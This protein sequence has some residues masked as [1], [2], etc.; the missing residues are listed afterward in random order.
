LRWQRSQSQS[1]KPSPE[2][3]TAP[4][5]SG[6]AASLLPFLQMKREACPLFH[7]CG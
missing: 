3:K 5:L 7:A 4:D 1:L 6:R 2:P